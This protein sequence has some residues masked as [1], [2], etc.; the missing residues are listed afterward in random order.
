MMLKH[1]PIASRIMAL[2]LALTM[3]I[4]SDALALTQYSTLE[5]GSRVRKC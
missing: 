5:F 4:A 2:A 3:L 1:R